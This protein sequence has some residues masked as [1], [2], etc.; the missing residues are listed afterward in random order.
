MLQ[1][2]GVNTVVAV[3]SLCKIAINAQWVVP[4]SNQQQAFSK[5]CPQYAPAAVLREVDRTL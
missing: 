5:R 2:V 1:L 4:A 3:I